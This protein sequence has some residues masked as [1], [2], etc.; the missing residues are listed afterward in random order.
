MNRKSKNTSFEIRQLV[1]FK[2][3]KNFSIREIADS[4]NLPK[5]TVHCIIQHFERENRIESIPQA[6]RPEKFSEQD[7]RFILRQVIKNPKLSAPKMAAE[8]NVRNGSKVSSETICRLLKFHGYNSRTARSKPFISKV[9]QEKCLTFAEKFILFDESYW[10]GVI[11]T[12][13]SKFNIFG[14]DGKMKIWRKP[15]T[16]L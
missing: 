15:N 1:I 8:I 9:N 3:E 5:S 10:N 7:K 2:H 12:N 14:S 4:L 13:E 16:E 6:G 11:F